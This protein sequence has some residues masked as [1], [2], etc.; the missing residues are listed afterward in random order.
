MASITLHKRLGVGQLTPAVY[1]VQ[2]EF[3]YFC[4]GAAKA[5]CASALVRKI[6]ITSS[7]QIKSYR[8]LGGDK[9]SVIN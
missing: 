4:F 3:F 6:K 2:L 5:V 7:L 9:Y 8:F 1:L